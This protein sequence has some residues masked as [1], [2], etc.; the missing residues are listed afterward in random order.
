[1]VAV[2]V[3]VT[4][5]FLVAVGVTEMGGLTTDF[6]A[7]GRAGGALTTDVGVRTLEVVKEDVGMPGANGPETRVPVAVTVI[8][9]GGPAGV[10]GGV[11]FTGV[12]GDAAGL[13]DAPPPPPDGLPPP[14]LGGFAPPFG[15]FP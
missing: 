15:L 1:P 2:T 12:A 9:G 4:V 6:V 14:P 3:T 10:V 13:G 11:P 8:R 5:T 7:V